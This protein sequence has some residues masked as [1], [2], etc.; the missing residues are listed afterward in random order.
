MDLFDVPLTVHKD[1]DAPL[2]ESSEL[3]DFILQN[4][5]DQKLEIVFHGLTHE[6]FKK[7]IEII[8][9]IS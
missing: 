5:K 6:M 7:Y 9:I 2:S 3:S 1:F 8:I 4:I